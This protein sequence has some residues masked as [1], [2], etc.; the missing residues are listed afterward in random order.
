[1]FQALARYAGQMRVQSLKSHYSRQLK[2]ADYRLHDY[3][4]R[5]R[6]Y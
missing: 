1:M 6:D 3:V 4:Y 2:D 5:L